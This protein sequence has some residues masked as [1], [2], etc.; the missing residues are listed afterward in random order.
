MISVLIITFYSFSDAMYVN[1]FKE[2][3]KKTFMT[4]VLI[5]SKA[6]ELYPTESSE[7]ILEELKIDR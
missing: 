6:K 5:R 1:L 2:K 4:T 7:K 3:S